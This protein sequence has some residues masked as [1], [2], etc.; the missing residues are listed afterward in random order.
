MLP[1]SQRQCRRLVW[2]VDSTDDCRKLVLV[3]LSGGAS[4]C[5]HPISH[6][7][8]TWSVLTHG[9]HR[10][11]VKLAATTSAVH[12]ALGELVVRV[13]LLR[14]REWVCACAREM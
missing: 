14:W 6:S 7:E 2:G 11:H 10:M 13:R 8:K 9:I 12:L 5:A 1:R 3:V 4:E